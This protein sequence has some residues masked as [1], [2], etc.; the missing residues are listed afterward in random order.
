MG[1]GSSKRYAVDLG[2]NPSATGEVSFS[3]NEP[4]DN[5]TPQQQSPL[6]PS[7]SSIGLPTTNEAALLCRIAD[8]EAHLATFEAL[9]LSLS[10]NKKPALEQTSTIELRRAWLEARKINQPAMESANVAK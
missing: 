6:P 4:P 1:Q 9:P 2:G 3:R 8:L 5:L 7:F 10:N